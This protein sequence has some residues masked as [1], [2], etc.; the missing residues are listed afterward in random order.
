MTLP[1]PIKDH[2]TLVSEVRLN[3]L[4]RIEIAAKVLLLTARAYK[5]PS[6][7]WVSDQKEYLTADEK[8]SA[9]LGVKNWHE[10][11]DEE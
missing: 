8:L 11:E 7:F 5:A 9:L 10:K 6:S 2:L 4:L 1:E 3:Q